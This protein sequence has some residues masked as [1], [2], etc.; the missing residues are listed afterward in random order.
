MP[1]AFHASWAPHYDDICWHSFADFQEDFTEFTLSELQTR[2]K[3]GCRVVDFGC[4]TGRL[5]LP[6]ALQGFQVTGV[7]ASE[8][9]LEQLRW[10]SEE[11]ECWIEIRASRFQDFTAPQPFDAAL[12][13]F[14]V[15][16]YLV[17]ESA[18]Q[19]AFRSFARSLVFGGLLMLDV[20]RQE[21]F[22]DFEVQSPE[23]TRHMRFVSEGGGRYR[24]EDSG[25]LRT[26]TGSF[27][28]S[29]T[30]PVR[31]WPLETVLE[32]LHQSGFLLRET[33]PE[34]SDS[35][36][37]DYLLLQRIGDPAPRP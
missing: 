21:L 31:F 1:E 15:I 25:E 12:C 35:Y 23:L 18:L 26:Q 19:A 34:A 9:L 3:P 2:L 22:E 8:P 20:P 29:E 37:S 13:L 14:T 16:S 17:D 36:G 7:D 30:V 5:A 33:F 11:L 6:L 27:R 32:Q 24:M 10:K 4:G 28:F